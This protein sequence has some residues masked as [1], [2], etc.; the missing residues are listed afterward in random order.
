[1]TDRNPYTPPGSK[2]ADAPLSDTGLLYS[3]RQIYAASFLGGP[4]SG[5][6]LIS[7]NYCMAS[8]AAASRRSIVLGCVVTIVWVLPERFPNTVIPIAYSAG[9][10]YFAVSK[11]GAKNDRNFSFGS[12]WRWW[13]KLIG[14][15]LCWLALT[16]AFWIGT[17]M[18]VDSVFPGFLNLFDSAPA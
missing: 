8:D 5:A 4:L 12:G 10:Y 11:F 1:M 13:L 7:R 6:W 3:P 14:V 2:V 18:F 9:F 17:S 16:M 15:A